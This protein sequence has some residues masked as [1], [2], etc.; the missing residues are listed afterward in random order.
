MKM[1]KDLGMVQESIDKRSGCPSRRHYGLFKC[2][3]CGKE[4]P[5]PIR[6]GTVYK[7]CTHCRGEI[8]HTHR[9]SKSKLYYVWQAMHQ[10]CEN[11]NNPKY[12]IYGAKGVKV[13]PQ[14]ETYEGFYADNKDKWQEGLTIDRIDPTKGYYPENVRWVTRAQNSSETRKRKPV[15]QYKFNSVFKEPSYIKTWD[16]AQNAGETLNIQPYS[17]TRC[18]RKTLK[19]AGGFYWR[20]AREED[21]KEV[22][23]ID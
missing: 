17:I 9:Q 15:M 16:S 8:Q 20:Y 23:D 14:W 2:P 4:Y 13:C 5:L 6:R 11:P 10:R 22:G 18:C 7:S 3:F 1:I 12:H 19:S 21:R